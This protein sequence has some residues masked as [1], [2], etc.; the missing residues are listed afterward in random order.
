MTVKLPAPF[1]P[2]FPMGNDGTKLVTDPFD[3]LDCYA[4]Y[5]RKCIEN[6]DPVC[7][8]GFLAHGA[9]ALGITKRWWGR[10]SRGDKDASKVPGLKETVSIIETMISGSLEPGGLKGTL[11]PGMA[12]TVLKMMSDRDDAVAAREEVT[13]TTPPPI[14]ADE[15][16]LAVHI[17]PDDPDPLGIESGIFARPAYSR[18][19]IEA[20]MPFVLPKVLPLCNRQD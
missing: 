17:H 3:L 19:Q 13:E 7:L 4:E 5:E 18:A 2:K 11:H 14:A 10:H 15:H 1:R 20:G 9:R 6:E 16:H 8:N 12:A